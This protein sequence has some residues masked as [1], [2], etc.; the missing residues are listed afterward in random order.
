MI[1]TRKRY[2]LVNE[3]GSFLMN[4]GPEASEPAV[5][6]AS[7]DFNKETL[8]L[9]LRPFVCGC[10]SARRVAVRS[11]PNL[12][13]WR[14]R[15]IVTRKRYGLVNETGSFLAN[16]GPEASEPAVVE[17]SGDF[18]KEKLWFGQRNW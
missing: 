16:P 15:M 13:S 9:G 5:V 18:N 12:P 6:E 1:V 14:L 4:P 8:W 11:R 2:G 17:A 7:D 10:L 3:T